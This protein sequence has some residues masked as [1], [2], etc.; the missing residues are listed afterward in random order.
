MRTAR[1]THWV[2]IPAVA[3]LCGLTLYRFFSVV[4]DALQNLQGVP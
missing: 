4:A 3:I 2:L 1:A